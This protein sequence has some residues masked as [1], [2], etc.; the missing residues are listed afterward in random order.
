MKGTGAYADGVIAWGSVSDV[1][2]SWPARAWLLF[3][4]ASEDGVAVVVLTGWSGEV[5]GAADRGLDMSRALVAIGCGAAWVDYTLC[6]VGHSL[7]GNW[8]G[9]NSTL[10]R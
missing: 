1:V 2:S 6:C 4:A 10:I 8:V 3:E 5:L 9:M 7:L